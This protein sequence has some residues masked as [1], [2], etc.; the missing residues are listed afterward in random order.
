MHRRIPLATF[1]CLSMFTLAA[2]G[3]GA[4]DP[5]AFP[6]D[7]ITLVV[8]FAAGGPTDTVTRLIA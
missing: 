3:G 5:A 8:P 6:D 1:A 2:C 4:P 7:D